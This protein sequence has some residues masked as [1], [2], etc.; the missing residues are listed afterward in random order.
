MQMTDTSFSGVLFLPAVF[1]LLTGFILILGF[2]LTFLLATN[3]YTTGISLIEADAMHHLIRL[4]TT[5]ISLIEAD[6][7]HRLIRLL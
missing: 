4:Y 5:G 7:M 1:F 6:A 2:F 3:Y